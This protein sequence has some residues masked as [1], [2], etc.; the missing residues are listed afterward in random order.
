MWKQFAVSFVAGTVLLAG[1]DGTTEPPERI[2]TSLECN[3]DAPRDGF[4]CAMELQEPA[5]LRLELETF[6]C[7]AHGNTIR[8]EQP[9]TQVLTTDACYDETDVWEFPG[10]FAEGRAVTLEII[11]AQLE[12][13]PGARVTGSY[14]SW[15]VNFEDGGDQDFDDLVLTVTAIPAG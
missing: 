3:T 7:S 6:T 15:V 5:G 9:V 8:M 13:D 2:V 10:P 4:N 12:F 14:P 11:S 1:C